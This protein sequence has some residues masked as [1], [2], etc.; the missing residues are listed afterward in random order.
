MLLSLRFWRRGAGGIMRT[1][2]LDSR[3]KYKN[4]GNIGSK[5]VRVKRS[6]LVAES[7]N[8]QQLSFKCKNRR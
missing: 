2:D 8:N 5:S 6:I 7:T 3:E 4:C 1:G